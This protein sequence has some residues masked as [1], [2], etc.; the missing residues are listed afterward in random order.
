[1]TA[2]TKRPYRRAEET[3][4]H[5]L[6]VAQR[7]FYAEGIRSVG[8]DRLA[9]EARIT[10]ATLY[11]LFGSKEG[12]IVGYLQRS[13]EAWFDQLEHAVDSGGLATLFDQLDQQARHRTYHGCPFRAA[14]AEYP[15]PD[16][17]IHRSA[18]DTKLRTRSRFR[19]LAAE[20]Q[21]PDPDVIADELMLLMEGICATAAER[22]PD[23][24][25]GPGPALARQLLRIGK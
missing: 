14:L 9:E 11:R 10:T 17:E 23:S 18:I 3:R 22:T 15:S 4:K 16:S 5:L 19:E 20:A 1:M 2:P 13:D 24:P 21:V 7:L 12:L 8:I 25:P 6:D